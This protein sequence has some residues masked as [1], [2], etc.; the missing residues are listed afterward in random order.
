MPFRNTL[1][2]KEFNYKEVT[3]NLPIYYFE[4]KHS[5]RNNIWHEVLVKLGGAINGLVR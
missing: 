5:K 4:Q 3:G 1:D 2:K